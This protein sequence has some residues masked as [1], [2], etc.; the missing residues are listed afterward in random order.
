MQN[1]K[2]VAATSVVLG[3]SKEFFSVV[4]KNDGVGVHRNKSAVVYT[5]DIINTL[6]VM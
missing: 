4:A 2:H 6:P 3:R 1:F 5:P